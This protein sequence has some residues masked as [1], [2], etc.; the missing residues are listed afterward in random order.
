MR[1]RIRRI[2]KYEELRYQKGILAHWK[3]LGKPEI[4]S[5]YDVS[6]YGCVVLLTGRRGG[7]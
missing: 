2:G 3:I 4:K 1:K 7:L 6:G 5:G